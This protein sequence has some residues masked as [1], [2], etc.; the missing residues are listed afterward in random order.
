MADESPSAGGPTPGDPISILEFS[1]RER[2][3]IGFDLHDG[4]AQVL[5]AALLQLKLLDGAEGDD[6]REGLT[7]LRS[8]IGL[9]LEETY[10]LIDQLQN[11]TLGEWSLRERLS[12]YIDD[13]ADRSGVE[14]SFTANGA[15]IDMTPSLR[16]AVFRIVQ[17]ALTNARR[18]ARADRIAVTLDQDPDVVSC[19]IVDDGCGFDANEPA[20]TDRSRRSYGLSSMR[21]RAR[22][23][24]GRCTVESDPGS[25]TRI[26]VRI[27]VWRG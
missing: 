20:P 16:I 18:H 22:L 11:G 27:P 4:P 1:E 19:S 15:D 25:G 9:A 26:E 14:V 23:L 10:E 12:S 24:D 13:F 21:E 17:E 7:E 2:S 3:R 5:S 6:L 8:M